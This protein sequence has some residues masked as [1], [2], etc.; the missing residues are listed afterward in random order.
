MYTCI[1]VYMV[2]IC[3]C[4]YMH[5]CINVYKNIQMYTE[6][7]SIPL[8]KVYMCIYVCMYIY[9]EIMLFVGK[10]PMD[11][12]WKS[13]SLIHE[14]TLCTRIVLLPHWEHKAYGVSTNSRL[15]RKIEFQNQ[16]IG[17]QFLISFCI[18]VYIYI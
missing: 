7:Y 17:D 4:E 1:D 13:G 8:G 9:R 14:S 2:Y 3:T 16:S 12:V 6:P 5:I 11:W 15:V 10:K 18:Y